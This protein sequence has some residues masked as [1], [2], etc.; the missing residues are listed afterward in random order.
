ML[1]SSCCSRTDT[2]TRRNQSPVVRVSLQMRHERIQDQPN[3]LICGK[4]HLLR[5]FINSEWLT[6]HIVYVDICIYK[7]FDFV[8]PVYTQNQRS[9]QHIKCSVDLSVETVSELGSRSSLSCSAVSLKRSARTNQEQ[10]IF[11]PTLHRSSVRLPKVLPSPPI[12]AL[13][14]KDYCRKPSGREWIES[15][16]RDSLSPAHVYPVSALKPLSSRCV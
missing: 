11:S 6:S 1:E 4:Y 7:G 8:G 13:E 10:R 2:E 14:R 5:Y 9:S 12:P 3:E 16:D 15:D